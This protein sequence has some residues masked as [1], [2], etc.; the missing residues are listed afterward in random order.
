MRHAFLALVGTLAVPV[1]AAP[2]AP[3]GDLATVQGHLRSVRAMTATFSQTDRSGK[4]LGG[5][6]ALKQPGRVRF[7]YERG[8]PILIVADGK[9]LNFVDYSV[10]QVSRW[11]IASSPLAVLLDPTRDIGR[12]A[13]IIAGGDPRIVSVLAYDRKRPE[14]GRINLIF[15]RDAAAPGGLMLTGWAALDAQGNRTTVRLA[16]QRYNGAIGDETFRWNDPRKKT[17]RN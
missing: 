4:V 13:S 16:D 3:S 2:A 14:Y 11:P 6:L 7:Q 15:A 17:A 8:V 10:K 9:T 12:Y 5:T 1:L